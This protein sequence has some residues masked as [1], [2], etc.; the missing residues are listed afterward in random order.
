MILLTVGEQLPFDRLIKAVDD[1]AATTGEKIIAQIGKSHLSPEN[2]EYKAFFSPV[3]YK[4]HFILADC[5]IA[6]AGMGSIITALELKKP[7]IIMPRQQR[8]GEHRTD[9]QFATAERFRNFP[10]VLVA[11][12]TLSLAGKLAQIDCVKKLS[13]TAASIEPDTRLLDTIRTFIRQ[14]GE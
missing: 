1:W 12:D 3:E 2:M 6:H 9:H 5:I 10:S 4:K 7:I 14:G 11:S 13:E 8:L